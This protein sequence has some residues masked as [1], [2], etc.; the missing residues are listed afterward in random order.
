MGEPATL[1]GDSYNRALC[2]PERSGFLRIFMFLMSFAR[3]PLHGAVLC[4]LLGTAGLAQ[5]QYKCRDAKG[6]VSYQQMP[7]SHEHKELTHG[8][9]HDPAP[10]VNASGARPAAAP[11]ASQA[12]VKTAATPGTAPAR[13]GLAPSGRPCKTA[14]EYA[15]IKRELD[16]NKAKPAPADADPSMAALSK[17]LFGGM[18]QKLADEMKACL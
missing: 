14:A 9:R 16:K 3:V 8:I 18:E 17:S 15:D 6:A 12:A 5:A 4:L 2:S 10:A 13:T 11:A 1:G 7:C